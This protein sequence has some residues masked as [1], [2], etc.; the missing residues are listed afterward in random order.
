MMIALLGQVG[1]QDKTKP[2]TQLELQMDTKLI[3]MTRPLTHHSFLLESH[4]LQNIKHKT[5]RQK[6]PSF[7]FPH[8]LFGAI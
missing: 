7:K 1:H 6:T 4:K 2:N 5:L 8:Q 3:D